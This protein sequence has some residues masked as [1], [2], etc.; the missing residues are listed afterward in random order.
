MVPNHQPVMGMFNG[1]CHASSNQIF[2]GKLSIRRIKKG[3]NNGFRSIGSY[4]SFYIMS[5]SGS[6]VGIVHG[7]HNQ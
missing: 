2:L 5:S 3:Y 4:G 1:I 6:F 7:I